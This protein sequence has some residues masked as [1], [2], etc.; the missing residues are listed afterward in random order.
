MKKL[1]TIILIAVVA[2]AAALAQNKQEQ[3]KY[4]KVPAGY[5]MV[6][7]QG[8]DVLKNIEDLAV[9]EKIQSANF[10]G[11]GFVNARFGFFN[12]K[13]KEY[14]PK[15]FSDVELASLTGSIAWQNGKPSLHTHGVVTDKN[16]EAHGGHLLGATVG[17]GSVEILIT[18]HDKRLER[19]KEEPL[20]AN[21]LQL[22]S[23]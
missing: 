23:K 21:V 10:S 7:R 6:L 14:E 5:L 11:M 16:F 9:A 8:E 19:I 3:K 17:T 2:N 1:I 22:G 20:G 4:I 13:T 12:F 18:V 15:D